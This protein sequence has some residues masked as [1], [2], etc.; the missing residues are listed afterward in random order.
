[1]PTGTHQFVLAN[2]SPTLE[3][4]FATRLPRTNPQTRVLFHGTSQDRLPNILAQGLK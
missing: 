2:A 3:N 1:L 4:W